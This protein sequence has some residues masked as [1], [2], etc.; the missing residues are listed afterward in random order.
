M[1][2]LITFCETMDPNKPDPI[3][4]L[5]KQGRIRDEIEKE[6]ELVSDKEKLHLQRVKD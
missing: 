2:P 1:I 4:L 6:S 5:K 3:Q